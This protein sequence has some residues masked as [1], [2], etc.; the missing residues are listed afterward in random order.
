M[1]TIGLNIIKSILFFIVFVTIC[2]LLGRIMEPKWR[3][4]VDYE[5]HVGHM[6]EYHGLLSDPKVLFMGTSHV[7]FGVNPMQIYEET[8]IASYD[9]SASIL[10][11]GAAYYLLK[12]ALSSHL[13]EIVMLDASCLY[14]E[15]NDNPFVRGT[16]MIKDLFIRWDFAKL[17]A[18]DCVMN[19]KNTDMEKDWAEERRKAFLF[20]FFPLYGYHSRWKELN[21]YDFEIEWPY[22]YRGKGHVFSTTVQPGLYTVNGMNE[23]A[24]DLN[25]V[26]VISEESFAQE[27]TLSSEKQRWYEAEIKEDRIKWLHKIEELCNVNHVRLVL[28]KVPAISNPI[29][30]SSAWT[31]KRHEA[32]KELASEEDIPFFDILYDGDEE[33]DIN[34]DFV[35]GGCHCN[36]LGAKKVSR[37]LGEY[38]TRE[39]GV[40]PDVAT[41]YER[42]LDTYHDIVKIMDLQTCNDYA[43]YVELLKDIS[44][45]KVIFFSTKGSGSKVFH[46]NDAELMKELG[47]LHA[48]AEETVGRSYLGVLSDGESLYEKI[49][50]KTA[51]YDYKHE[52]GLNVSLISK[53]E[54]LTSEGT[55]ISSIVLNNQE[56]SLNKEGINLVIYDRKTQC[57]IDSVAISSSDE[58]GKL[59]ITHIVDAN[60]LIRDYQYTRYRL[61]IGLP[62]KKHL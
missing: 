45:E 36:Y 41:D 58:E 48:P 23:I 49:S 56:Y 60:K 5:D 55:P 59:S 4:P 26:H 33:F 30:Y 3:Y 34:R 57:I 13:P 9:V 14:T 29:D 6:S 10:E 8:G 37:Q 35:D 1:K 12:D 19:K 25:K 32:V 28:F 38:L 62:T 15:F 11:L 51:K 31:L 50:D 7:H 44:K 52:D 42:D 43:E 27:E 16:Q 40:L 61:D 54:S 17:Y 53:G 39:C 46:K 47:F 20:C 22:P 21:N 24:D 18:A 2:L